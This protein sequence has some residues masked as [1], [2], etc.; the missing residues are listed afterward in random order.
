MKDEDKVGVLVN[1]CLGYPPHLHFPEH[2]HLSPTQ[3]THN[4]NETLRHPP[5]NP[6]A[7]SDPQTTPLCFLCWALRRIKYIDFIVLFCCFW[8]VFCCCFL[9][10]WKCA[11]IKF[12]ST[13]Y[14]PSEGDLLC[15]QG[16]EINF[17]KRTT[18][19]QYR[20]TNR[21]F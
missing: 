10:F 3:W 4:L 13:L 19:S 17:K 11:L 14:C 2:P 18:A 20:P 16:I 5:V 21:W 15:T 1:P 9:S 6:L 12:I 8:G 7:V